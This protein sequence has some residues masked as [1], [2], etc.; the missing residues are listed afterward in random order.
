MS[1]TGRETEAQELTVSAC[2]GKDEDP[3]PRLTLLGSLPQSGEGDG[4]EG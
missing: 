4:K 1:L 2:Q 3:A